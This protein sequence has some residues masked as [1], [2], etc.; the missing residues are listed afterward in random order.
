VSAAPR[1]PGGLVVPA[2]RL[3]DDYGRIDVFT[4]LLT[5]AG[6]A[7]F[8]V[9][10]G[11]E[12][13]TPPFLRRLREIAGRPILLMAD[14]ERAAGQLVSGMPELPPAMAIGATGSPEAAYTAGKITAISAR[15]LSIGVVLAPVLDV[16]S[17]ATNP[18]AGSRCF[19]DDPDVTA[20]LGLAFIEGVQEEGVLAC[21]KHFPGHGDTALDSHAALPRVDADLE[22]LMQRELVPFKAAARAGVGMVMTA[23][24][25]YD[26]MDPELPATFSPSI[27]TG[28]LKERFGY[29]GLVITDA[30]IME[31]AKRS[32]VTPEIAALSAGVD[33]LLCPDDPWETIETIRG[34][35]GDGLVSEESALLSAGK[36]ALAAADQVY[37]SPVQK[38]FGRDCA[39]EVE[40]IARA[41]LTVGGDPD[42][43]LE[44][45]PARPG[46][47]CGVIIDDDGYT[48][49]AR[50]FD[51]RRESFTGGILHVT[52]DGTGFGGDVAEMLRRADVIVMGLMGD[53]K[54]WKERAGLGPEL[55]GFVGEVLE[56]HAKK[57]MTIVFGSPCL[58]LD[59]P[60][61]NVVFAYGDTTVTRRTA[62][63]AL[64]DGTAMPGRL[65]ASAGPGF[66]RGIGRDVFPTGG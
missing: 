51:A 37:D 6:V 46:R 28:L 2:I 54:A 39:F 56:E 44:R 59:L 45:V 36:A 41:S 11:D 19:S 57:T 50:A 27:V 38:D 1:V 48:R 12:E 18:I 29:A 60:V 65:P 8:I 63:D 32:D 49:R 34:A 64:F 3:P 22:V 55:S 35:I 9:Y 62:L 10:G 21:A 26:A 40:R 13:L 24:A 33:L 52:R 47:V 15:Y 16:L 20:R 14:Y 61:R 23:H 43:L 25:I 42:R 66:P 5:E 7:G 53:V 58:V 17:R 30:L 4:R 31:G